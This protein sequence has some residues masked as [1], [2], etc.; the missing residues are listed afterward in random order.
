[1]IVRAKKL[2]LESE[3]KAEITDAD[4]IPAWARPYVTAAVEAKLVQGRAQGL[5]APR[6]VQPEPNP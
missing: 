1:M 3:A 4:Q 6:L 5:F 2:R